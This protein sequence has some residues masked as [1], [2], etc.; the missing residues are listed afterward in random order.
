MACLSLAF[1][2]ARLL[3][4]LLLVSTMLHIPLLMNVPQGALAVLWLQQAAPLCTRRA[5]LAVLDQQHVQVILEVPRYSGVQVII[6]S[7][8]ASRLGEPTQPLANV[9]HVR[10]DGEIVSTEAEQ[11]D[12]RHCL[13]ANPLEAEQLAF[14]V[15]VGQGPAVLEG[16]GFAPLIHQ[17]LQDGLDAGNFDLCQATH[18]DGVFNW[19]VGGGKDGRPGGESLLEGQVGP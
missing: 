13:W 1:W 11:Q 4:C 3:D 6:R 9:Q 2:D 7:L 19:F 10:V 12:T 15:F 14:C 16:G 18:A 17:S 8:P 5:S